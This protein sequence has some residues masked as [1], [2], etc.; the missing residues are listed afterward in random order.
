MM[1]KATSSYGNSKS[2]MYKIKHQ[3][4][5]ERYGELPFKNTTNTKVFEESK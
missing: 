2:R 4:I 3:R 5:V 1:W